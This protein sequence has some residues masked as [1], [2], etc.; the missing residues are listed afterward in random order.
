VEAHGDTGFLPAVDPGQ[1]SLLPAPRRRLVRADRH[2]I[3][4]RGWPEEVMLLAQAD[5]MATDA[6]LSQ[7]W[8]RMVMSLLR[9]ALADR[10]ADGDTLVNEEVLDQI[11]LPLKAA[12]GRVLFGIHPSTAVKYV[13]AAHPDKALPSIR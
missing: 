5:A 1:L 13:N 2:R 12:G 8:P 6:G 7:T 4:G 3:A 11:A 9:L 10:D